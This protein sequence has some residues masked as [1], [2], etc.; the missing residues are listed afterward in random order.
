VLPGRSGDEAAASTRL[1]REARLAS[2]LSHYNIC[3][4]FEAGEIGGQAFIAMERVAGQPLS[5]VVHGE[6]LSVDR[7][8]RLGTQMAD[9]LAHAHAQ[10]VIHRDLKSANVFVGPDGRVKILDF[11]LATRLAPDVS[12]RTAV[13]THSIEVS[14]EWRD[15]IRSA[16]LRS[17]LPGLVAPHALPTLMTPPL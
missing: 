5:A 11:G 1:L 13:V 15:E 16:P 7:V 3:T 14:G 6:R 9:G 8:I 2:T 17:A 12:L 10:G 4:V